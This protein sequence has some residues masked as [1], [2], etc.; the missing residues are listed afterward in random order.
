MFY[1]FICRLDFIM[2]ILTWWIDLI[3]C[4]K[5]YFN[6]YVIKHGSFLHSSKVI[7]STICGKCLKYIFFLNKEKYLWCYYVF[8]L[9]DKCIC[10]C[11]QG[12]EKEALQLMATYLPKDTSPGSAYQEGGGLYALGLI[13]A[14]HGGEIID[15]LLSQLKSASNDVSA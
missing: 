15:Y 9:I 10:F 7:F 13:H 12:H 2:S 11:V 1:D 5:N 8:I 3:H 14:N 4:C 6:Y